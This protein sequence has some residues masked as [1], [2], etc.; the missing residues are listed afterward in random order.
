MSS[1]KTIYTILSGVLKMAENKIINNKSGRDKFA[2]IQRVRIGTRLP[3]YLPQRID[4]ELCEILKEFRVKA[5][6]LGIKQFFIQTHFQTPLELTPDS[7]IAI[8]KLNSTGWQITNQNVFTIS[9]SRK[10]HVSKLREELI[11]LNVLP[12]YTFA[13]KG[14]DENRSLFV[15]NAR[16]VQEMKEEKSEGKISSDLNLKL[17]DIIYSNDYPGLSKLMDENSL[18]FISTDRNIMNLPGIG[19]SLTFNLIG[20]DRYGSRIL[21]FEYDK[22]RQHSPYIKSQGDIIIKERRSILSYLI[23]LFD[24]K[25]NVNDYKSIWYYRNSQTES[26]F[27]FFEYPPQPETIT[28]KLNH[29]IYD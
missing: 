13:V 1:N 25:E 15:P 19:K 2:V 7:V 4:D 27:D 14:F 26:R 17:T 23:A 16:L 11:K 29:T 6:R 10:G 8:Q 24:K 20:I 3:V 22:K 21:S 12:Y 9:A 18:P 5:M 28:T